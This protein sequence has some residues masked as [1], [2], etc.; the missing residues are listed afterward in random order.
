MEGG[1]RELGKDMVGRRS[2]RR[3]GEGVKVLRRSRCVGGKGRR[4]SCGG[5]GGEEED[6]EVVVEIEMK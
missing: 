5:G 3:C 6:K 1:G 2:L 4:R